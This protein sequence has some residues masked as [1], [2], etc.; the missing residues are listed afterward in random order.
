MKKNALALG[1][2]AQTSLA[3]ASCIVKMIAMGLESNHLQEELDNNL[4]IITIYLN[5]FA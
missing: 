1:A 5:P 2:S 4:C 3:K